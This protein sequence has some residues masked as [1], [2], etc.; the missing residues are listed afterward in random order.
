MVLIRSF[1][2]RFS[3]VILFVLFGLTACGGGA[4]DSAN[5][6]SDALEIQDNTNE[7][8]LRTYTDKTFSFETEL[9]GV[10]EDKF[11]EHWYKFEIKE[12]S[13]INIEITSSAK[14]IYALPP[15]Y[16]SGPLDFVSQYNYFYI[17]DADGNTITTI[18]STSILNT[19][20]T[21]EIE[22][23]TAGSY[24]MVTSFPFYDDQQYNYP[25][26]S[27]VEDSYTLKVLNQITAL[28][29]IGSNG[30]ETLRGYNE[31][32]SIYGEDGNDF[33]YGMN[34][35]DS[36]FGGNGN[37]TIFGGN[38][39]DTLTG[40]LGND[41]FSFSDDTDS[42]GNLLQRDTITDFFSGEDFIDLSKLKFIENGEEFK[43]HTFLSTGQGPVN[44]SN[45]YLWFKNGVLYGNIRRGTS[46]T[47]DF[48][49]ALT[50]VTNLSAS[51]IIFN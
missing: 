19:N 16:R 20:M 7:S 2:V 17:T 15:E 48:S 11:Q 41:V 8:S 51:D 6:D 37:D 22:L 21:R 38:G 9:T 33:I 31:N 14:A 23:P 42:G 18:H 35:S 10:F 40:G 49:V 46:D 36:L 28:T 13:V 50:G 3:V 12:P 34:G 47:P 4:T 1:R 44:P 45:G 24:Y 39:A 32:Q 30:N 29:I 43:F 25:I 26:S 5:N 27:I